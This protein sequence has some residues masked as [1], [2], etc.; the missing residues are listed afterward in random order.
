MI[1]HEELRSHCI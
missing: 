1:L